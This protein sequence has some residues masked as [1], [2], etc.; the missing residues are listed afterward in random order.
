MMC[1]ASFA[2]IKFLRGLTHKS[3]PMLGAQHRKPAWT[4]RRV[5]S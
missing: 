5:F 1:L 4:A 2:V 3:A